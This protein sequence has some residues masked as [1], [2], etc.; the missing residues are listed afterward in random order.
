M[1]L[2]PLGAAAVAFALWLGFGFSVDRVDRVVHAAGLVGLGVV[3]VCLGLVAVST[4]RVSLAMRGR[5]GRPDLVLHTDNEIDT[6][7]VF[8][9]LSAWPL[10]H[11]KLAWESPDRVEVIL[12]KRWGRA[13][14]RIKPRRRGQ[15]RQVVRRIHV[16]D[17]FGFCRISPAIIRQVDLRVEPPPARV[18]A[19]VLSRL[20]AGDRLSYPSALPQGDYIEM[21]RYAPG[22]PLRHILWKVF[23]RSRKL[24]VRTQEQAIDPKPSAAAYLVAGEGDEPAAGAARFFVDSGLLGDDFLFSADGARAPAED[25]A[26]ALDLIVGSATA[27]HDNAAGLEAF[28]AR[29]E[30]D[31]LSAFV[32]FVPHRPGP[33]VERVVAAA[34]LV[35]GA[36]VVTSVDRRP[37]EA[38]VGRVRRVLFSGAGR[39][40]VNTDLV[41]ATEPLTRVGLDVQ[42]LH[43]PTGELLSA[44]QIDALARVSA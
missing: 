20:L 3:A 42:V 36:M 27:D 21:R 38:P 14:E 18:T 41:R 9:A 4:L 26:G 40:G 1:P 23:A 2:T 19:H 17:I 5:R 12:N 13:H 35:P 11:L 33:W 22:D 8:P 39:G 32:L 43:R 29:L 34:R 28:L 37:A 24:M 25:P 15:V 6:G 16:S 7:L 44:A 30:Q 10:V 31:R